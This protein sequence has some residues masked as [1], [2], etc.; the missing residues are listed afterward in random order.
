MDFQ[1]DGKWNDAGETVSSQRGEGQT[2][3]THLVLRVR[4][5]SETGEV[6]DRG[7]QR[8]SFK[9]TPKRRAPTSSSGIVGNYEGTV[10]FETECTEKKRVSPVL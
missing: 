7:P 2:L 3:K 5:L 6:F 4:R 9:D 8:Q 10:R 1:T